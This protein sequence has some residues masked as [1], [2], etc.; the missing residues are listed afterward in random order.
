M[1]YPIFN[2]LV[3]VR[4]IIYGILVA[5]IFYIT[6]YPLIVRIYDCYR[7]TQ[8]FG[9]IKVKHARREPAQ[10]TSSQDP[11]VVIVT[12]DATVKSGGH[13]TVGHSNVVGAV[14]T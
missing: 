2:S 9:K 11:G 5:G 14:H 12:E 10:V 8:R 13:R 6:S 3:I 1:C 7:G 4:H